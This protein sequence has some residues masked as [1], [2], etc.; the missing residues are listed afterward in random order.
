[1]FSLVDPDSKILTKD[2]NVLLSKNPKK[3][4]VY[5]IEG[6]LCFRDKKNYSKKYLT[7][8]TGYK[9]TTEKEK[10]KTIITFFVTDGFIWKIPEVN[11]EVIKYVNKK[12]IVDKIVQVEEINLKKAT[13]YENIPVGSFI[14]NFMAYPI[15]DKNGILIDPFNKFFTKIGKSGSITSRGANLKASGMI[16]NI[17]KRTPQKKKSIFSGFT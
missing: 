13:L 8:V 15:S 6:Y 14:N 17:I 16:V 10:K 2:G 7:N 11:M 4:L 3:I 12:V 9:V 1:M 5:L